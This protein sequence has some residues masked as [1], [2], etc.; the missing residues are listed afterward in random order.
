[1][2]SIILYWEY[3]HVHTHA[4]TGTTVDATQVQDRSSSVTEEGELMRLK[5]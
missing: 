4:H 1:M 3:T 5:L 2:V